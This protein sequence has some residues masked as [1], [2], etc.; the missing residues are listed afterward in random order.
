VRGAVSER[1]GGEKDAVPEI[2]G[3]REKETESSAVVG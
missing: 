2:A 1:A 3:I